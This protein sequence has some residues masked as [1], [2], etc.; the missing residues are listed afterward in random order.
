MDI[1]TAE[2]AI[3]LSGDVIKIA[4]WLYAYPMVSRGA[5]KWFVG[6]EIVFFDSLVPSSSVKN[7]CI[8]CF[9]FFIYL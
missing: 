8:V 2:F 6:T 4:A 1:S 7:K 3:Q 5:T 9:F